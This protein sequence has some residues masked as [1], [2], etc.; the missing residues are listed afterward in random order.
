MANA[1]GYL[2]SNGH[3]GLGSRSLKVTAHQPGAKVLNEKGQ[4]IST[5]CLHSK[6]RDDFQKCHMILSPVSDNTCMTVSGN[7]LHLKSGSPNFESRS[8]HRLI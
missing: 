8:E 7:N 4:S 1:N 2:L 3:R 5:T 6:H